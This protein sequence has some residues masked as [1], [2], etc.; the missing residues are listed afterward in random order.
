MREAMPTA[1]MVVA[2]GMVGAVGGRAARLGMGHH[3]MECT[4]GGTRGLAGMG[5][6][7]RVRGMGHQEGVDE[8]E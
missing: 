7:G 1:G 4:A 5:R 8:E 3:Q 2:A 6:R